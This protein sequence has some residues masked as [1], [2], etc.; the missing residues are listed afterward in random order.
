MSVLRTLRGDVPAAEAGLVDAH[1][2]LVAHATPD[3]AAR[4][5]DLLL[6]RPVAVAEDLRA[7][8][9]AGGG[10]VVEMT[11]VDYGRDL[12][13]VR[14]LSAGTGVHVVAATGFNKGV[15][16]RPYCEEA[17]P[18]ALAAVQIRDIEAHGCGVVKF[19]TSLDTIAPWEQTALEAAART[20][21]ATGCPVLTHTEAGTMAEAQLDRL[22][23]AGVPPDAVVLGHLDRN[24]DLELHLRLVDRGAHISYD[25]LPKPKY[26]AE[27]ER[28]VAHIAA[29]AERGLAGHVV[30][31]GDL[32][33]RSYFAGWGGGPGLA[34]LVTDFR[35]Q[36][37]AA[38]GRGGARRP[39]RAA[40]EPGARPAHARVSYSAAA[41]SSMSRM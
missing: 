33:R 24:P 26:A 9:A 1:D 13:A 8:A 35:A 22:E 5:P 27:R 14:A 28:A 4:D 32:A 38:A 31:G 30:V 36:L 25:Q 16:C 11:T 7:F 12:D 3:L 37:V 10:T 21:L 23:R 15:Y 20:H 41:R 2:H 18:D 29:L 6:D 40:R 19:G 17:T 39:P 34:W